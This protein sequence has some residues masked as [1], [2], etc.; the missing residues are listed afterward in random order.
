MQFR[1]ANFILLLEDGLAGLIQTN[2]RI[3]SFYHLF[4]S[5]QS[6]PGLPRLKLVRRAQSPLLA[7][8]A[9]YT[10]DSK[11]PLKVYQT[12]S[13]WY[14]ARHYHP[15]VPPLIC[16]YQRVEDGQGHAVLAEAWGVQ[17]Y[18]HVCID[19]LHL[20]LAG[21]FAHMVLDEGAVVLHAA[22]MR[23][24]GQAILFCAASGTGKTTQVSLWQQAEQVE[25]IN[26]DRALCI[27]GNG[28]WSVHGQPWCG[29]SRQ[30]LNTSAPLGAIVLLEQAQRNEVERL[31]PF[32]AVLGLL[33]RV[34]AFPWDPDAAGKVIT[35]LDSIT[36]QVP[37]L[38][39]RC[40]PD[41]DA[42][43]VLRQALDRLL[44]VPAPG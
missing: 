7:E 17:D 22:V 33:P 37:V 19:F 31:P 15:R 36:G 10:S 41:L 27:P 3:T 21:V 35:A 23:W 29:A 28:S 12:P 25:V 18:H 42:V 13:A 6:P 32:D 11:Y 1:I 44:D 40:R 24:R 26:G 20:D 38:R 34:F 30:C 43:R 5:G 8:P 4:E 14:L 39:L 2:P 9:I 16:G